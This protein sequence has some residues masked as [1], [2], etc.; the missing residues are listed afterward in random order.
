MSIMHNLDKWNN[1]SL[2][3]KICAVLERQFGRLPDQGIMAGQAVASALYEVIGSPIQGRY[4][5]LDVFRAVDNVPGF[6]AEP[7]K[8]GMGANLNRSTFIGGKTSESSFID[9]LKTGPFSKNSYSI[10]HSAEDPDNSM[11][12]NIFLFASNKN[13][14]DIADTV[15]GSF[16]INA[17]Q[18][19]INPATQTVSWT[20]EFQDFLH[21]R[22]LKA[23]WCGTPIHTSVRLL[24]KARDMQGVFLNEATEI[25]KLQTIKAIVNQH[26]KGQGSF[27]PGNLFS[28]VY[29]ERYA[30]HEHVLSRYWEKQ[31][32]KLPDDFNA[33]DRHFITLNPTNCCEKTLAFAKKNALSLMNDSYLEDTFSAIIR[34][35]DSL[36]SGK[37]ADKVMAEYF[38]NLDF[39]KMRDYA[40]YQ[41]AIELCYNNELHF[42]TKPALEGFLRDYQCVYEYDP[43]LINS[44]AGKE[45]HEMVDTLRNISHSIESNNLAFLDAINMKD[46]DVDAVASMSV[47]DCHEMGK[48]LSEKHLANTLTPIIGTLTE[49][50]LN[51]PSQFKD[52][53]WQ[54]KSS[55]VTVTELVSQQDA[56]FANKVLARNNDREHVLRDSWDRIRNREDFM[57]KI[58]SEVNGK[59]LNTLVVMYGTSNHPVEFLMTPHKLDPNDKE[60]RL[61][62]AAISS[63]FDSVEH[64]NVH[65]EHETIAY[66]IEQIM[67]LKA[68]KFGT[69]MEMLESEA[70]EHDK[71]HLNEIKEE[72]PR[73]S[74]AIL[75]MQEKQKNAFASFSNQIPF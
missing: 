67:D 35:Y 15:I 73:I 36:N 75:A 31:D 51:D 6:G 52:M 44:I 62:Y 66:K 25:R 57:F 59:I 43:F 23:S 65:F 53:I 64:G 7:S 10:L 47:M 32:V 61:F 14:I 2:Y 13:S 60:S 19:A 21:D 54:Q 26:Q 70:S 39:T 20:Q 63:D 71:V 30:R 28:S 22:Q 69:V 56:F 17:V 11:I 41:S 34:V 18:V 50:E 72:W 3:R 33:G 40:S 4:K 68:M 5:D 9:Q 45:H 55:P 74:A 49:K 16:D 29:Q 46:I 24:D 12:N 38:E 37:N 1:K 27:L 8:S 58:S 48:L 42:Y